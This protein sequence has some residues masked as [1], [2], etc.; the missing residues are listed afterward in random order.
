[1]LPDLPQQNQKKEADFGLK[2][3]KWMV[4]NPMYSCA[5]ETKYSKGNTFTM[6][7]VEPEQ[8][9]WGMKIRSNE[10]VMVRVIGR[11]GEPDYI[12]CRNMPSYIVIKYP[13]MFCLIAVPTFIQ[14]RDKQKSLTQSR[15]S[16]IATIVVKTT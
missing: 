8:L 16:D 10:G 4:K 7:E 6:S 11:T 5:L 14:E 13:K 3:K 9:A 2:L 1:M 15:A 12:W